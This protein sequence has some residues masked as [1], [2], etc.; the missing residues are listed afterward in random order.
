MSNEID[1]EDPKWMRFEK[2][3]YTIQKELAS[4]AQV[5]HNDSIMG[6]D[7]KV[8]RQTDISIREQ[9][10]QYPI[11]VVIDCK[12]LGVPVDVKGVE[13]FAGLAH[14]VRANRGAM[15]SS[16][17]FTPAALNVA[18]NHGIDTFRLLD[19]EGIDWKTYVS[20]PVLLERTY[21]KACSFGFKGTGYVRLPSSHE[22]LANMELHCGDGSILGTP[23]T[24]M[25]AKWLKKEIPQV[26]GTHA[27]SLGTGVTIDFQEIRSTLDV[28][29]SVIVER[30]YYLGPLPVHLLGFE[31]LQTGGLITK[32]L[33]TDMIEPS[34]IEQGGVSEWS[35]IDNPVNLSI[36][37]FFRLGYSDTYGD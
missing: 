20:V 7:S 21:I 5:T 28:T 30:K 3:V 29:A 13:E 31:D 1:K 19:T 36:K 6:V 24:I 34:L 27:V 11:L 8:L 9:I 4:N 25:H 18:K 26:S 37:V 15:I 2:L 33:W 32:K 17:G 14:D 23:K 16:N 12:D 35:E 10:G 22:A